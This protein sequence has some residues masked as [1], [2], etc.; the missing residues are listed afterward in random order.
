[1]CH[2]VPESC[3]DEWAAM[4]QPCA[5]AL[6]AARR[7][8]AQPGDTVV[9]IGVGGIGSFLLAALRAVGVDTII[10]LDVDQE[11]LATA[12]RLGATRVLP[13]GA[14]AHAASSTIRDWTAGQGADVVIEA[15]GAPA[16]TLLALSSARRGGR[17]LQVGL[18]AEPTP[19]PLRGFT[20][21]EIDLITTNGHVCDT[22][23]PQALA[24][25]ATSDLA[26]TI[27]DRVIPL[28]ALV[29]EGLLALAE[30]RARGK[31]VVALE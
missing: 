4:A 2:V 12:A 14:D 8:G 6:H 24:L 19:L 25:L 28:D 26:R 20:V 22:D 18:P 3:P 9:L 15:S 31:V 16:A 17:V 27:L 10:A 7:S 30:R 1:M 21:P 5:I 29:G 13:V 11:R 23:L